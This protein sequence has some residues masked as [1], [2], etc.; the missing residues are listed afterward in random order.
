MEALNL[1]PGTVAPVASPMRRELYE[2][3]VEFTVK[4]KHLLTVLTYNIWDKSEYWQ[5][6]I[7][8]IV[9]LVKDHNPDVSC[10]LE[11]SDNCYRYIQSELAKSYIIFRV[12]ED[13]A[14]GAV[15]AGIVLLC[16]K[17][18]VDLPE[19]GQPYYYDYSSGSG[20]VIGVE[21]NLL[22][23]NELIN[24]LC[25]KLDDH[26]DN[27]HV[28]GDQFSMIQQVIKS[29][30]IKNYIVMGDFNIF[31]RGEEVQGKILASDLD[32]AWTKMGCPNRVKYTFDGK[33][34]RITQD[35]AQLRASRI[36]YSGTHLHVKALSFIGTK[37]ISDSLQITPSCH[38]GLLGTFQC[39]KLYDR[40]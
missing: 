26:R 4:P 6:R 13:S 9:S 10:L 37:I 12:D 15:G 29:Q 34:N 17:K 33:K 35:R 1:K 40:Y 8:H 36:Y 16:N 32:D 22:S 28:R 39:E 3:D 30:K 14:G 24:V 38:Y 20:R 21:L 23:N 7:E 25:T 19:G 2:R 5:E 11:V 18:T 27:D 31:R